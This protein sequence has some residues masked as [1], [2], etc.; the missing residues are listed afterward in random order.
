MLNKKANALSHTPNG[1]SGE[2]FETEDD[3]NPCIMAT[4]KETED[5]ECRFEECCED[6]DED[7][8]ID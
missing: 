7:A 1:T 4:Q 5:T 3:R 6:R 2:A 8:D